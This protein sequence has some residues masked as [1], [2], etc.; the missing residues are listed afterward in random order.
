MVVIEKN[1]VPAN[2]LKTERRGTEWQ[3][4][5]KLPDED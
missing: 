2:G 4:F 5:I 3:P 1:L